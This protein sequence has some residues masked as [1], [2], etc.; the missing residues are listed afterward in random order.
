[1]DLCL[2]YQRLADASPFQL[3][4][5]P[6]ARLGC[7]TNSGRRDENTTVRYQ[8]GKVLFFYWIGTL[9]RAGGRKGSST[10]M[11]NFS[12]KYLPSPWRNWKKRIK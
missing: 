1:M 6:T 11:E 10:R 9:R 12:D 3:L 7:I 5:R 4:V 8:Q 2:D